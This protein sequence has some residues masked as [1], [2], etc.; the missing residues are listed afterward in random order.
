MLKQLRNLIVI[1]TLLLLGAPLAGAQGWEMLAGYFINREIAKGERK[2]LASGKIVCNVYLDQGRGN[3]LPLPGWDPSVGTSVAWNDSVVLEPVLII[4]GSKSPREVQWAVSDATGP[5][6]KIQ[7]NPVSG[8]RRGSEGKAVDNAG[9]KYSSPLIYMKDLPARGFFA[10]HASWGLGSATIQAQRLDVRDMVALIGREDVQAALAGA[11]GATYPSF[12]VFTAKMPD[13][14]V[15]TFMSKEEIDLALRNAAPIQTTSR[16]IEPRSISEPNREP[17]KRQSPLIEIRTVTYSI[18][19]TRRGDSA[20]ARQ[21]LAKACSAENPTLR[22]EFNVPDGRG[23]A[24]LIVSDS[25]FDVELRDANNKSLD[26]F[27]V[28]E[29]KIGDSTVY[30]CLVLLRL[31]AG[32][33]PTSRLVISSSAGEQREVSFRRGSS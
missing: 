7:Y 1:T 2:E 18:N 33:Q 30:S 25:R 15:Q 29:T 5:L 9:Y 28:A 12:P 24:F 8:G 32:E 3:L 22:E 31:D 14:S 21:L 20:E 26:K 10:L 23:R 27:S 11:S 6:R 13:G 19:D 4:N 16:P 17:A